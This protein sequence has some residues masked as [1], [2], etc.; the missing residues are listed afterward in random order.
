MFGSIAKNYDWANDFLSFGIR[1]YW[2]AFFVAKVFQ[3]ETQENILDLCSGSGDI[4]FR[5]LKKSKRK[6]KIFLLDFCAQMLQIARQKAQICDPK[7]EQI[8]IVQGD[9]MSLPFT[10]RSFDLLTIAYGIRNVADLRTVFI[11]C[12]RVLKGGASIAILELTRPKNRLFL[13]LYFLYLYLVFP[14]IARLFFWNRHAYRYLAESI[15]DFQSVDS[16]QKLLRD[17][18]FQEIEVVSLFAGIATIITAKKASH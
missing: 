2:N 4:A 13:G 15:S 16:I 5:I 12:R 18:S 14:L 9:A 17:L 1:R 11:E 8:R 3:N 10:A 6:Q 7:E